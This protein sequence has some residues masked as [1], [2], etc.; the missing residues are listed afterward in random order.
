[1]SDYLEVPAGKDP[2]VHRTERTAEY[3]ARTFDMLKTACVCS[4]CAAEVPPPLAM[5]IPLARYR[6]LDQLAETVA[7][8]TDAGTADGAGHDPCPKCNGASKL[9]HAD[10]YFYNS[11]LSSDLVVRHVPGA[12]PELSKW[13]LAGGTTAEAWSPAHD[14]SIARDALVRTLSAQRGQ[15]DAEG[16]MATLR[17]AVRVIPGDDELLKF[18]SWTNKVGALDLCAEVAAA[19]VKAKPDAAEGHFWLAQATIEAVAAGKRPPTAIDGVVPEL[20]RAIQ[21]NPDYPDALIALANVSRIRRRDDEAEKALRALIQNHPDHPEGN[22]TLGLVLLEKSPAEALACFER[23]EKAAPDDADYPRSRARALIALNRPE[24][25]RVA[26]SRAK[27]LAPN[28]GRIDQVASQIQ[29]GTQKSMTMVIRLIVVAVLLGVL[30]VVAWIVVS[31]M[32]ST[33]APAPPAHGAP[34]PAKHGGKKK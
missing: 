23:G 28:D 18:L 30:G 5:N 21:L 9:A 32:K 2:L 12:K 34:P 3:G 31:S 27:T 4:A 25:A 17:E 11:A 7:Q 20:E 10:Y 8:A 1:M 14:A 33:T 16:S 19:H 29:T 22:Y 24:E 26:I 15:E 13:S 6:T